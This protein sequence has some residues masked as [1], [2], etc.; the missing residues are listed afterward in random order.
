MPPATLE[1]TA[2]GTYGPIGATLVPL[3]AAERASVARLEGT[4]PEAGPRDSSRVDLGQLAD[5]ARRLGE[6]WERAL[7]RGISS[8]AEI[9][10]IR[11]VQTAGMLVAQAVNHATDHRA[12][13]CKVLGAHRTQPPPLDPFAYGAAV[14][15][16]LLR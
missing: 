6:D 3:L 5:Q 7:G 1:L 13:I 12:H 15:A 9:E 2:P 14:R 10:T 11:G 4:T 16:P 8:D